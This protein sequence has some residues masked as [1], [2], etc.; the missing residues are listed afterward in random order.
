MHVCPVK[1]HRGF[2]Y[3]CSCGELH[4]ACTDCTI[5]HLRE[6]RA[7][8]QRPYHKKKKRMTLARKLHDNTVCIYCKLDISETREKHRQHLERHGLSFK[9]YKVPDSSI[10]QHFRQPTP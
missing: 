2:R 3:S 4:H 1:H 9:K 6:G 5:E 10:L 8:D 7:R